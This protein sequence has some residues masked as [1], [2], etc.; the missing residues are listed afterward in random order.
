MKYK[1]VC[2]LVAIFCIS[3]DKDME[4][5]VCNEEVK[6]LTSRVIGDG[7]DDYHHHILNID[8]GNEICIITRNMIRIFPYDTTISPYELEVEIGGAVVNDYDTIVQLNNTFYRFF[9]TQRKFQFIYSPPYT[10]HD[11]C[12]TPNHGIGYIWGNLFVEKP[13][14][15]YFYFDDRK[16]VTLFEYSKLIHE[17]S[18]M[19][20]QTFLKNDSLNLFLN[21]NSISRTDVGTF[22]NID[23]NNAKIIDSIKY[24]FKSSIRI[25]KAENLENLDI[26]Y[27]N[28]TN[29]AIFS[30]FNLKNKIESN[31]FQLKNNAWYSSLYSY[32]DEYISVAYKKGTSKATPKLQLYNWKKNR[33]IFEVN[34]PEDYL[35]QLGE[36][37]HFRDEYVA[38]SGTGQSKAILID[39]AGCLKYNLNFKNVTKNF[40]CQDSKKI[41]T[42]NNAGEVE[43]VKLQI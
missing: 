15:N 3:C 33:M 42:L 13:K 1:L 31:I 10:I 38:L 26:R 30:T 36:I 24:S 5:I 28:G 29:S 35:F 12:V 27:E 19:Y 17:S 23:L 39:N 32:D 40:L 22:Y 25:I 4:N 6:N 11:F 34:T 16:N 7:V 37:C 14:F 8:L 21:T 18:Y 2:Y 41:V 43:L 20:Y 9:P